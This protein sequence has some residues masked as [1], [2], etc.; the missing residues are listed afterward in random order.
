MRHPAC[1]LRV[2]V[3]P[4]IRWLACTSLLDA[5]ECCSTVVPAEDFGFISLRAGGPCYVLT[6]PDGRF[7]KGT[8]LAEARHLKLRYAP[9]AR[10]DAPKA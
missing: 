4:F 6:L 8:C 9:P 1:F 10:K 3:F 5:C 7:Y 2:W